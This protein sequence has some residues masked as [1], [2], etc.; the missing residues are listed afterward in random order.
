MAH[1]GAIHD[2][3]SGPKLPE[4]VQKGAQRDPKRS[5]RGALNRPENRFDFLYFF[6]RKTCAEIESSGGPKRDHVDL[7]NGSK[8]RHSS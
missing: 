5:L 6:R 3:E 8:Q 2:D 4:R 7:K 1:H